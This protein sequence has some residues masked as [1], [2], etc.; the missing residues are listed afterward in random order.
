MSETAQPPPLPP[1]S[2][3]PSK[4][5]YIV[6][7]A[8]IGGAIIMLALAFLGSIATPKGQA[9]LATGD[10]DQI[11]VPTTSE[12]LH[13]FINFANTDNPRGTESLVLNGQMFRVPS[14]TRV[15]V[16]SFGLAETKVDILE[17]AY[18]GQ[19]GYVSSE[20]IRYK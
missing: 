20:W 18:A 15:R 4:T 11:P 17:G 8:V 10:L 12:N 1:N 13:R 16:A 2:K 9:C 14:G 19:F 7:G 5:K 3:P 6:I